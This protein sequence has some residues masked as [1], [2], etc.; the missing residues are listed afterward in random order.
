MWAEG[1]NRVVFVLYFIL[2][3]IP[4]VSDLKNN[5]RA[6]ARLAQV[7]SVGVHRRPQVVSQ[8][9]VVLASCKSRFGGAERGVWEG[10]RLVHH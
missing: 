3:V 1:G 6:M 8:V 9:I 4:V 2:S 5:R 7:S 10:S